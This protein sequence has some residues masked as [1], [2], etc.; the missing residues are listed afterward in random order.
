M[1]A[2]ARSMR[3]LYW[4]SSLLS[5]EMAAVEGESGSEF[6][7][8]VTSLAAAVLMS[9]SYRSRVSAGS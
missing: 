6:A 9:L 2:R 4:G 8:A 3:P 5:F 1:F 7:A